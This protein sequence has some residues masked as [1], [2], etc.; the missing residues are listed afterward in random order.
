MRSSS[1]SAPGCFPGVAGAI[2]PGDRGRHE[3]RLRHVLSRHKRWA[4]AVA[5]ALRVRSPP[6]LG[7]F[8]ETGAPTGELSVE[9]LHDFLCDVPEAAVVLDVSG[10]M[11][12]GVGQMR[13]HAPYPAPW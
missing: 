9:R 5:E 12:A 11:V 4:R 3:A 1:G 8:G 13:V 10:V 7:H 6:D 2:V